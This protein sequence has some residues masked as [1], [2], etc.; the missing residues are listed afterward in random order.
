M[1]IQEVM[2]IYCSFVHTWS[3]GS[4]LADKHYLPDYLPLCG[5]TFL[6]RSLV[7][8]LVLT[9][10]HKNLEPLFFLDF[11]LP[12]IKIDYIQLALPKTHDKFI[13]I[14]VISLKA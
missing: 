7:Q 4:G 9:M 6:I 14:V 3:N 5:A 11:P 10:P 13:I 1:N 8:M 12:G 2:S